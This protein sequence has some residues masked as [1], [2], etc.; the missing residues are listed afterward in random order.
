MNLMFLALALISGLLTE[1]GSYAT[2][3]NRASGGATWRAAK[4]NQGE[5]T[6]DFSAYAPVRIEH[7]DTRAI[8]KRVKPEY[9]PEAM[10]RGIQ[11]LVVV[12]TL[13]NERGMVERTCAVE[14]EDALR[15]AAETAALQWKLK[16][17]YGLAFLRPKT[18]INPKNYAEVY[19]VFNFKID[20]GLEGRQQ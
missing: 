14:G 19:L 11:G 5:G 7:F 15:R 9:P 18:K 16:P 6:C 1:C 4:P 13:V 17:S 3:S 20:E 2:Q 10:K 8:T 12:K